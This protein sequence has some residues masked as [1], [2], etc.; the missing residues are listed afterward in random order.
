[1]EDPYRKERRRYNVDTYALG[2]AL[3]EVREELSIKC[4]WTIVAYIFRNSAA[5][6]S[7]LLLAV[8]YLIDG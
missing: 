6:R 1:M 8:R 3:G 7:P 4:V 2:E 5:G